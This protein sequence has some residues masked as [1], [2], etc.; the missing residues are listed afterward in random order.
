M[1][2][3]ITHRQFE[4]LHPLSDGNGRIGR[5]LIALQLLAARQTDLELA[6]T[7]NIRG[8][9]REII[10]YL[11]GYPVGIVP[12]LVTMTSASFPAVNNAIDKLVQLGVLEAVGSN[13]RR[14]F[15]GELLR[16]LN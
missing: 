2:A 1:T 9:G 7:N 3:A 12:L 4:T 15:E 6:R 5:L 11:I 8:V 10:D 14:F 16:A 13:P